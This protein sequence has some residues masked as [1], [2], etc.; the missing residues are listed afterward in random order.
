MAFF[1]NRS[2]AV[3]DLSGAA[4][5]PLRLLKNC[6]AVCSAFCKSTGTANKDRQA[7]STTIDKKLLFIFI[8]LLS[9]DDFLSVMDIYTILCRHTVETY[10]VNGVPRIII[11]AQLFVINGCDTSSSIDIYFV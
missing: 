1:N 6:R 7:N 2:F 3:T 11:N 4:F 10:T 5:L 8:L 9:N